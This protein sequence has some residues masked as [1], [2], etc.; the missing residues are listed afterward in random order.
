M[1]SDLFDEDHEL[2]RVSV[3]EFVDKQMVRKLQQWDADRLTDCP[4]DLADR[5]QTWPLGIDR[6]AAGTGSVRDR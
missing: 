1:D 4:R 5:R 6:P 3:R 2:F